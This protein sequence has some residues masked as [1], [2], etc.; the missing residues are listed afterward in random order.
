MTTWD[1]ETTNLKKMNSLQSEHIVRSLTA[2]RRGENGTERYFLM[3]EWA[4]GGT[5]RNL[6]KTYSRPKLTAGLV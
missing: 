5:L 1:M 4:D 3:F 2:F 6:W